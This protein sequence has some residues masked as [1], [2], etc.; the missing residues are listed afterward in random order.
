MGYDLP[1]DGELQVCREVER[2]KL[3]CKV[4]RKAIEVLTLVSTSMIRTL[5]GNKFVCP[6]SKSSCNQF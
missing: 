2:R 1:N 6:R 3:S 4:F 5:V